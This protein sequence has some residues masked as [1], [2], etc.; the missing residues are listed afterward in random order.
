MHIDKVRLLN[1]GAFRGILEVDLHPQLVVLAGPNGCGK[2]TFLKAVWG[3]LADFFR[4]L[5]GVAQLPYGMPGKFFLQEKI[6]FGNEAGYVEPCGAALLL[7][8]RDPMVLGFDIFDDEPCLSH[9]VDWIT[10]DGA[11]RLMADLRA[12]MGGGTNVPLI[13]FVEARRSIKFM[14]ETLEPND[15]K[16]SLSSLPTS[17]VS[18][19]SA[20]FAWFKLREDIENERRLHEDAEHRDRALSAVR[21]AITRAV[22]GFAGDTLFYRR[23]SEEFVIKKGAEERSFG[24]LSAGEQ[25]FIVLVGDIARRLALASPWLMDPLLGEGIILI[26]EVEQ[27]LHPTWQRTILKKL[28]EIFPNC[29][30]IVTTHSPTV[31]SEVAAESI[32]EL[33]Q[34]AEGITARRPDA[35]YGLDVGAILEDV[36][37]ASARPVEV[38]AQ[39]EALLQR[40]ES[41]EELEEARREL[42]ALE[43]LIG[44][45]DR[46][47]VF[48]RALL[49]RKEVLGR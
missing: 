10:L 49:R 35:S 9:G 38:K 41:G 45:E 25:M 48:A 47:L 23:R 31:L 17:P 5:R 8:L 20:L 27:H 16:M 11:E 29:Q 4:R 24:Q 13:F 18:D 26:D 14:K 7:M 34:G 21:G 43:R 44:P 6:G 39:I 12:F 22:P 3:V 15:E 32:I 19:F 33:V 36:M 28:V 37:G 46:E 1:I 2:T 30:F 42:S 40:I